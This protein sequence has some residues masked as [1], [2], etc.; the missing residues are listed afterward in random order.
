MYMFRMIHTVADAYGLNI[1]YIHPDPR[2]HLGWVSLAASNNVPSPLQRKRSWLLEVMAPADQVAKALLRNE[3]VDVS[4]FPRMIS[5]DLV[6][7]SNQEVETPAQLCTSWRAAGVNEA[8]SPPAD[9]I[10][11]IFLSCGRPFDLRKLVP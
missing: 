6:R 10:V 4:H 11:I 5:V 1:P 3:E 2:R 8:A 9:S 7:I